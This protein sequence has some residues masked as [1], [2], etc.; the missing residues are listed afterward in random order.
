V[1]E[2]VIPIKTV[3]ESNT[4]RQGAWRARSKRSKANRSS[5]RLHAS[6]A[7]HGPRVKLPCVITMTRLSAG[8]LD[9]DGLRSALK[10]T[11]DGIADWLGVDDGDVDLVRFKYE[12]ES[13]PR[14]TY[15]VRVTVHEGVR[16]VERLEKCG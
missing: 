16:L 6:A 7:H 12:Q 11:R 5:A 8:T 9:D 15:A 4:T 10:A 1:I 2:F 14:K 3:N 13:A